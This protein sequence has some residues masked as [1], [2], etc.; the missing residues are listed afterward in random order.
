MMTFKICF[1]ATNEEITLDFA[2]KFKRRVN[3]L[4]GFAIGSTFIGIM[5][6]SHDHS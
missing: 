5:R 1:G 6:V 2:G 4:Y 3:K